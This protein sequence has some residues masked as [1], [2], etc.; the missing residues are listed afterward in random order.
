MTTQERI[1]EH[2]TAHLREHGKPPETVFAVCKDLGITERDFFSSF[3]NLESV[4]S[5]FWEARLGGVIAG[6]ASGEEWAGFT[7]KQRLLAFLFAYAEASLDFRSLALIRFR[8]LNPLA[9]P[10]W[11]A[12]FDARFQG[13]ARELV[14]RGEET[15]EIARRGK[16]SGLYPDAIGLLFR[17][18]IE[19]HLGDASPGYERTDAYIEKTV[20]LAFSLIGTQAVDSA[21]D[22]VRFLAACRKSGAAP[23]TEPAR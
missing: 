21:F 8:G 1:T 3:P 7:A 15:G 23:A 6:V 10:A 14:A 16:L 11:I 17:T 2:Y 9:K 12:G 19:F 18:V 22:L 13:F 5:A 20:D 4:E